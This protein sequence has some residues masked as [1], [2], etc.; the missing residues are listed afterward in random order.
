MSRFRRQLWRIAGVA[1]LAGLQGPLCSLACL[2]VP[3]PQAAVAQ[4][5]EAP[6]HGPAPGAGDA[7]PPS[8]EDC[9]CEVAP[10]EILPLAA[11]TWSPP[12]GLAAGPHAAPARPDPGPC[13][14]PPVATA[15]DLPPPDI[16]LLKAT[17]VV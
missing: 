17:L 14:R 12:P 1:A 3:M 4:Q 6:C 13:W 7:P 16:L 2:D 10:G 8:R 15:T 9:G 11:V 5:A